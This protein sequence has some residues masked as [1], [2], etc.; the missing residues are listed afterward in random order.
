[1]CQSSQCNEVLTF[2]H[3]A[4]GDSKACVLQDHGAPEQG[5]SIKE[6]VQE[7]NSLDVSVAARDL[8]AGNGVLTS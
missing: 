2:V 7:G 6:V 4:N 8:Q 5:V 1:M 3:R